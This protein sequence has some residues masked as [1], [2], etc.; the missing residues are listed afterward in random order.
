MVGYLHTGTT[1]EDWGL[2]WELRGSFCL[3]ISFLIENFLS[4]ILINVEIHFIL[5]ITT[6]TYIL[7][8]CLF[9]RFCLNAFIYQLFCI[10]FSFGQKYWIWKCLERHLLHS[11]WL[12]FALQC[13]RF[14]GANISRHSD[15]KLKIP[16]GNYWGKSKLL[17]LS[18]WSVDALYTVR[19]WK[20]MLILWYKKRWFCY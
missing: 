4:H 16:F 2:C 9:R 15:P 12:L 5:S 10:F 8:G 3:K 13:W 6:E 20:I 11:C 7:E 1:S 17:L 14:R 19:F 18:I